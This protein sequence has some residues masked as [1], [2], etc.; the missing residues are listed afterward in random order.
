MMEPR[1]G[2]AVSADARD[3]A[4]ERA[5]VLTRA[6]RSVAD[7]LGLT[8]RELAAVLGASEASVSRLAKGARTVPLPGKEAEIAALLVRLYRS[9]DTLVGGSP[10]K[11]S[12]WFR[13]PNHHLGGVPAE[14]VRSVEGL[15]DVVHYL[16]A[17]RG[18]L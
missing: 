6:V 9:L 18:K 1:A 16:D 15:V 12:A 4:A 11:A 2:P 7:L 5:R 14:R 13:A 10:E 8:Q 17:M 3:D